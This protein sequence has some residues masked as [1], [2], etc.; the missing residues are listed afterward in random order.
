M[1]QVVRKRYGCL[2]QQSGVALQS[3]TY[4]KGESGPLVVVGSGLLS[5]GK[6][7]GGMYT[8]QDRDDINVILDSSDR[9][10]HVRTTLSTAFRV[11]GTAEASQSPFISIIRRRVKHTKKTS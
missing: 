9:A 5:N 10:G 2:C 1:I 11:Q 4:T 3:L 8:K 7:K 6:A